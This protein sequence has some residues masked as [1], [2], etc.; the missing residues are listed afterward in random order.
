LPQ[1]KYLYFASGSAETVNRILNGTNEAKRFLD[2]MN[3]SNLIYEYKVL[4]GQTH[5][6]EVP[7]SLDKILKEKLN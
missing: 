7:I 6:S 3:Y 4:D 1:K 5:N 2:K